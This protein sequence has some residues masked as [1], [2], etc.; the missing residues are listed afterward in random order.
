[1]ATSVKNLSV[2]N[3]A[4]LPDISKQRFGLVVSE[5]N[6]NITGNLYQGALEAL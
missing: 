6:Q 1:M 3:K 5:W 4:D 2:Y